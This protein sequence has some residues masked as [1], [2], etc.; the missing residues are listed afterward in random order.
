MLV[1]LGVAL[2]GLFLLAEA[3]E[4]YSEARVLAPNYP[5]A[6]KLHGG[7]LLAL[8]RMSHAEKVW[9]VG[10]CKMYLLLEQSTT[11]I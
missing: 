1:N 6:A 8:G 3:A 11:E 4:A 9:R 5:K 2:E 7:V 10:A